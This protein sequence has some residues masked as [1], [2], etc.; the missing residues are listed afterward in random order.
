MNREEND[1]DRLQQIAWLLEKSVKPSEEE[2]SYEPPYGDVTAL[3]TCRVILDS[4]G[5]ETLKE[6]AEDTIDLLGTSVAVYEAN[7]D[8][9]F[10]MF[11]SGWCRLMDAASRALCRTDDNREALACGKWLCHEN[12]WNDSAKAAIESGRSTDIPCVGGIHLYGEPIYAGDRVVGA[13]NIGYGDPPL[14]TERLKALAETFEV[15]PDDLKSVGAFYASRPQFIVDLAKKRLASSARLIGEMVEKAEATR[16][17]ERSTEFQR[18]MTA[19]SPVALY[20]I[21]LDGNVQAW[22]TSA[23]KVFGWSTAEVMGKPLPIVPEDKQEEYAALRKR[24]LERDGFSN[25]EVVRQR[26]DGTCF[27][28]S[29]SA[30]PIY[31]ERGDIIGIM[32]SMADITERKRAEEEKE[33]MEAQNRQLQKAESLGRMAGA[34]AHHFNNQLQAVMGNLQLAMGELPQAAGPVESM[35]EAMKAARQAARVSGQMLTYLGQTVG[36]RE[37]L[38]LADICQQVLPMLQAVMPTNVLLETDLPSSGSAV[39]ADANQMEQVITNLVTNAWEAVGDSGGAIHLAVETVSAPEIPSINRFPVDWRPGAE[40]Y[41]SLEVRDTG[42]GIPERDIE[43][44]FDPFYSTKFTGRGLG[45]SV[46]LGIVRAH[47][48]C[49]V[50][51]SPVG[52]RNRERGTRNREDGGQRREG[53]GQQKEGP[54]ASAYPVAPE[55][56]TGASWREKSV[57][58]VFRVYLPLSAEDLAR[59]AEKAAKVPELKGSGKALLIEDDPQVRD[60]GVRMLGFLGFKVIAAKDGVKG[61]EMFREHRDEIRFVLSDL[62]MPRMDG[63]ATIAALRKIDPTIPII[64]ASGYDEVSV[65][66]GDHAE[67]PQVFLGKPYTIEDLREAIGKVME[68]QMDT[69]AHG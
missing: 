1:Q 67:R 45:L 69:D 50:V 21:D 30:G 63:W 65:M 40:A 56:G 59:P 27:H 17:L 32:S 38:N 47:G 44:V 52:A 41:A 23:E 15:D 64:L 61:V 22:N 10:G 33:A 53:G 36:K 12:C 16:E 68:P 18:A 62:T 58:G 51:E 28:A 26:K 9:A 19:C 46:V 54:G 5:K 39:H 34:I 2:T 20:S 25:V 29:L 13:L 7:G 11:S 4:V 24:V 66:S 60:L 6:I 57:G 3:N 37:T 43:K 49:I 8:Y 42:P 35:T 14:D 55:D 48:G 31:D